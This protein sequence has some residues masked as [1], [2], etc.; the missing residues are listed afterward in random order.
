MRL[1]FKNSDSIFLRKSFTTQVQIV[2][3]F[4]KKIDS[5]FLRFNRIYRKG[6]MSYGKTKTTLGGANLG[7]Y[8]SEKMKFISPIDFF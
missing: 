2:K 6:E 4:L 8:V 7:E 5:E 3:D 1:N